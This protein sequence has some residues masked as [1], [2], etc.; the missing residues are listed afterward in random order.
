MSGSWSEEGW[1]WDGSSKVVM[2]YMHVR[3]RRGHAPFESGY[4]E[5]KEAQYAW[6]QRGYFVAD[7]VAGSRSFATA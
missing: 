2:N 3:I 5:A 1:V 6:L 4:G 7:G